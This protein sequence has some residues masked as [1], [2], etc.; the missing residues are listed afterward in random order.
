MLIVLIGG[1]SVAVSFSFA[2]ALGLLLKLVVV[3]GET[4][5]VELFSLG[6]N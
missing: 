1:G 4:G 5:C 6:V 2:A 3:G